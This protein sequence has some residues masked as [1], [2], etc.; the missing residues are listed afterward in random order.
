MVQ[1]D[2]IP[3]RT[4]AAD[5]LPLLEMA[6]HIVPESGSLAILLSRAGSDT[7]TAD[8]RSWARGLTDAAQRQGVR[9]WPVHFANGCR[10]ESFAPDD[11]IV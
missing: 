8:D 3:P 6:G 5:C 4:S 1:I 11:L 10:V 7:V 2:D 9:M